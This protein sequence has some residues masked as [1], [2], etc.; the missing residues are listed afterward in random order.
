MIRL[1]NY[2]ESDDRNFYIYKM[3]SQDNELLYIGKTTNI[4]SRINQHF[5]KD[6]IKNQPWKENVSYIDYYEF[7]S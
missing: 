3:Y 1:S 7:K 4:E 5:S 6:T 2:L